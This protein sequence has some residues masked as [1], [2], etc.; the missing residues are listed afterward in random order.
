MR[1]TSCQVEFHRKLRLAAKELHEASVHDAASLQRFMFV[2]L[3][4]ESPMGGQQTAALLHSNVSADR[5]RNRNA[6][7]RFASERE[8]HAALRSTCH[9]LEK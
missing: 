1:T 8:R 6:G 7:V 9:C 2:L 3:G 4:A 5:K